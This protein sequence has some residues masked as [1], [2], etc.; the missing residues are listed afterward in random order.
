MLRLLPGLLLLATLAHAREGVTSVELICATRALPAGGEAQLGLRFRLAPDWHLY[1]TNPGDSGLAPGL[2]WELPPGFRAGPARFPPPHRIDLTGLTC[3]G[4]ADEL[5]LVVPVTVPADASGD[6]T[7]AVTVNWMTCADI[8]VE[9][10]ARLSLTLPVAAEAPPDPRREAAFASAAAALPRP[11][12]AG[13]FSAAHEGGDIVL[14]V[15]RRAE[16]A[17]FFDFDPLALDHTAPQPVERE[18]AGLALRLRPAPARRAPLPRLQ[19]VVVLDGG[20]AF[21]VDVPIHAARGGQA[22]MAAFLLAAG[23]STLVLALAFRRLRNG[24][25]GPG[26]G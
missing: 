2:S 5:F 6:A 24:G 14:R 13:A 1:W 18:A 9:G 23:I 8:C 3:Y 25:G 4:Y 12:P 20:R 21:T 7:L 19:G 15:H 16:R 10:E 22:S 26:L 17:E 11:A